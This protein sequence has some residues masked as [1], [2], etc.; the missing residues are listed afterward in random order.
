MSRSPRKSAVLPEAPDVVRV[1]SST[2][3]A[4]PRMMPSARR[5]VIRSCRMKADRMS[6]KIGIVVNSMVAL[7]GEV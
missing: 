6:V 3:P 1:I 2:A 5:G 7:M 4:K